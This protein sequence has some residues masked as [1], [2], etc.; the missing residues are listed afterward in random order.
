VYVESNKIYNS[1]VFMQNCS[2]LALKLRKKFEIKHRGSKAKKRESYD[3]KVDLVCGGLA[4]A[5][6]NWIG[7]LSRSWIWVRGENRLLRGFMYF[8]LHKKCPST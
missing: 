7:T 8:S 6:F 2:S 3:C 5:P 1:N 4:W